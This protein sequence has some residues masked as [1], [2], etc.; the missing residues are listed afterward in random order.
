MLEFAP[1]VE[2]MPGACVEAFDIVDVHTGEH[3]M[4]WRV[5][6]RERSKHAN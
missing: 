6:T 4:V 5:A 2:P 3:I 1:D